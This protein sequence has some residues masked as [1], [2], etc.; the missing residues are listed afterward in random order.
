MF[1]GAIFNNTPLKSMRPIKNTL[2]DLGMSI[3]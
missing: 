1:L 3:S 2:I